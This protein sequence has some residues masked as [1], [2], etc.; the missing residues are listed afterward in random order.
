MPYILRGKQI[1]RK[2]FVRAARRG[3]VPVQAWTVDNPDDM[4]LLIE[5]GVTGIISDRPDVAMEVIESL[6]G[7]RAK[8]KGQ[9]A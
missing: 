7:Q 5:W 8:G 4:R 2:G 3:A 1:L 9:R 6:E